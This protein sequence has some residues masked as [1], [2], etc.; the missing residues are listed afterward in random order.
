MKSVRERERKKE[1]ESGLTES[2]VITVFGGVTNTRRRL[3]R[4][5]LSLQHDLSFE[6]V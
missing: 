1:R 3:L 6:R 2:S 4:H 5:D